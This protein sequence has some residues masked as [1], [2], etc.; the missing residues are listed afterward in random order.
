MNYSEMS[1]VE[2]KEYAKK[3]GISVGNSGKEKLIEKSSEK[4]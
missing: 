1:L 3:I 2:L 4:F